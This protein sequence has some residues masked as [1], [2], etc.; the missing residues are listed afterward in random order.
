M[1]VENL[2]EDCTHVFSFWS[3]IPDGPKRAC[4]LQFT[5]SRSVQ[6]LTIVQSGLSPVD[7][8]MMEQL[9]GSYGFIGLELVAHMPVKQVGSQG[10]FRA[11]VM[12]KNHELA[13]KQLREESV[14]SHLANL[15]AQLAEDQD[16][17][18][19]EV[20]RAAAAQ[21]K[22]RTSYTAMQYS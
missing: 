3:G 12:R 21:R 11:L 6:Y 13:A 19:A 2:P 1:Q 16:K 5:R 20:A 4:G 18:R 8:V 10:Q 14:K 9:G 22:S 17:A 7:V 15:E